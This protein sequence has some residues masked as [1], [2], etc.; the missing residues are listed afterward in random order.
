MPD[1]KKLHDARVAAAK[2]LQLLCWDA[3]NREKGAFIDRDLAMEV[4]DSLVVAILETF[5]QFVEEQNASHN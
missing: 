1:A 3:A 4:V 2:K 5:D